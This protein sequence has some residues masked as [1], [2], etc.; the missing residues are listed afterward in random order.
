MPEVSS[1]VTQTFIH[2]GHSRDKRQITYPEKQRN[3]KPVDAEVAFHL[4]PRASDSKPLKK[5]G[6]INTSSFQMKTQL[7]P[8][9]VRLTKRRQVPKTILVLPQTATKI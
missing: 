8:V 7:T 3:P 5:S 9:P 6:A 1:L 4:E 2:Q